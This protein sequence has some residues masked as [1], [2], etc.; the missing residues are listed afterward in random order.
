MEEENKAVVVEI[1]DGKANFAIDSNK[2]GEAAVSISLD[3]GEAVQEAIA[4]GTKVEGAKIVDFKFEL[5]KLKL[6]I[7][8]D[9]DGENLLDLVIDLG[10]AF[11]EIQSLFKK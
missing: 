5:T 8:T 10:E 3:L 11:D 1:K 4:K 9:K 6:S 7:D 2:D